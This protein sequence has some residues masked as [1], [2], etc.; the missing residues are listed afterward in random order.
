[1]A[2]PLLRW[3]L[4]EVP[5]AAEGL[6][7][8]VA[9]QFA[10]REVNAATR[11]SAKDAL[12]AIMRQRPEGLDFAAK[13]ARSLA[14]PR[15]PKLRIRPSTDDVNAVMQANTTAGRVT[16][17]RTRSIDDLTGGVTQAA[18]D[19]RRVDALVKD[20]SAPEGY[21][22]RLIVDDAGNV[23]EGQHRLEAL[24][25]LGVKDVPVTEYQDFER[26]LPDIK[27]AIASAQPM[28]SDH[29]N[30]LAANLAEIYA[31]EG[32]NV[33]ALADYEVPKGFEA[34]WRA[35]IDALAAKPAEASDIP[36][37][38]ARL[39]R[40]REQGFNVDLP[41]YHGTSS[42]FSV[43]S[44]SK[45]IFLTDNPDVA[46]IYATERAKDK[47]RK[48]VASGINAD[49]NIRP[50]FAKAQKPL[51]I[52]DRGPD[53]SGGWSTDNLATALGLDPQDTPKLRGRKLYDEARRQGYD[54]VKIEDME[55]LGGPQSQYV[56][57]RPDYVK[58][59]FDPY[60]DALAAKPAEAS[61]L[62]VT[63]VVPSAPARVPAAPRASLAVYPKGPLVG[64]R[65]LS[66]IAFDPDT[67]GL[68]KFEMDRLADLAVKTELHRSAVPQG[69]SLGV[70]D[71]ADHPIIGTMS[72]R[73]GADETIT[74]LG[75]TI[76]DIPVHQ[77]GGQGFM[78][79]NPDYGWAVSTPGVAS[80]IMN[81][82]RA[83]YEKYGKL[84]LLAP[85][86][87][88]GTGTD[89]SKTTGELM[90]SHANSA[91][92]G[93]DRARVNALMS[94]YI[95]DFKGIDNPEGY[96]QYGDLPTD[97]RKALQDALAANFSGEGG[98][99]LPLTRALI[100]SPEQLD[101][102]SFMLQNIGVLDPRRDVNVD[103]SRNPTYGYNLPVRFLGTMSPDINLAE[104]LP[105]PLT[106]KYGDLGDLSVF[107]G[108]NAQLSAPEW[109][110][111]QKEYRSQLERFDA[112]KLSKPP[113]KP[114]RTGNSQKFLQ[115]GISG[116]LDEETARA[117]QDRLSAIGL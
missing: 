57:L 54:L 5:E 47:Q 44:P 42:D 15:A 108:Q 112:G 113:R 86:R 59:W 52:S 92:G 32:G 22:S 31:D 1:M 96:A 78:A 80:G 33:A 99:S 69:P 11:T 25:R 60:S 84:P 76:F 24:R 101:K 85:Y 61:D 79:A 72:D 27:S 21:I 36:G 90:M 13:P 95:R 43:F 87:M 66:K 94:S 63:P 2:N 107:R 8:R 16:G 6:A 4:S 20:M 89:F 23:I 7:K 46:S 115:P 70:S 88:A 58:S 103:F 56:S 50:V 73:S 40:A 28:R 74:G 104:V 75:N 3:L 83:L 65:D 10:E 77:W 49:P 35:G 14:V 55:D 12:E 41:L 102:P 29:V 48:Y 97:Q 110:R 67:Y 106:R 116:F 53:G 19:Q 100:T 51:V 45:E 91:F 18:D 71:I 62:A 98:L 64:S 17:N 82:G 105:G 34:G 93:D 68:R 26:G 38:A 39:E 30:Q 109:R 37:Q 81:R 9:A 111:Q 117:I 114:V